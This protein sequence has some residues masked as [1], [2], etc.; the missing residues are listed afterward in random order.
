M[1]QLIE[2]T[3]Q[4]YGMGHPDIK[5]VFN[6]EKEEDKENIRFRKLTTISGRKLTV[7]FSFLENDVLT[8]EESIKLTIPNTNNEDEIKEFILSSINEYLT[9]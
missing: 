8:E 4:I 7:W 5:T 6:I 9:Q 3:I 2:N 1:K